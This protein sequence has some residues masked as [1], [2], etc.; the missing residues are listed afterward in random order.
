MFI[1]PEALLLSIPL[2]VIMG[3]R[4]FYICDAFFELFMRAV[5][6][7]NSLHCFK[8]FLIERKIFFHWSRFFVF[9]IF[10]YYQREIFIEKSLLLTCGRENLNFFR[11]DKKKSSFDSHEKKVKE[12]FCP[13]IFTSF[14]MDFHVFHV[15]KN[16]KALKFWVKTATF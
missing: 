14:L 3:T 11:V 6:A 9:S 7:I 4:G 12:I 10:F 13:R 8:D 2:D 16:F 5:K 15:I 1:M